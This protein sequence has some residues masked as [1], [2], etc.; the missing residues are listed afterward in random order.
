MFETL[1]GI[2]L[3][4]V[5]IVGIL[6]LGNFCLFMSQLKEKEKLFELAKI[7]GNPYD[8]Y[9]KGRILMILHLLTGILIFAIIGISYVYIKVVDRK[10]NDRKKDIELLYSL[11]YDGI[12]VY[13]YQILYTVFDVCIS[14]VLNLC[15]VFCV[16]IFLKK[17]EK[18]MVIVNL[19]DNNDIMKNSI[20]MSCMIIILTVIVV[21][22]RTVRII[23]DM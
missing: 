16:G 5:N 13:K 1:E 23:K 6:L 9:L 14:V 20:F 8:E 22:L 7:M 10:T 15:I 19:I 3:Y 11:G 4:S 21:A 18:L 2:V 17:S 12:N